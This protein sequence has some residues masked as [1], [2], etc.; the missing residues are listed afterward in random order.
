MYIDDGSAGEPVDLG[1]DVELDAGMTVDHD[2]V[3][4]TD[5]GPVDIGPATV[6]T[7]GDGHA[8]TA[9]V[10][11]VNG[12]TIAYTDADGD[13]HAD[14]ATEFTPDGQ[15]LIAEH[16]D[17]GWVETRH[18]EL[19]EDGAYRTTDT[20]VPFTPPVPAID[21]QTTADAADDAYWSGWAGAFSETGSAQGVVRIDSTTGQWISQN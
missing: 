3:I 21:D 14:I 2:L 11:D 1:L 6:D 5:G 4:D 10:H 9:I 19:D 15:V 20:D 16:T 17:H 13:G 12:D 7:D 18:G 8:D